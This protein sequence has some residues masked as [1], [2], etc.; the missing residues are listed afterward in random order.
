MYA[1]YEGYGTTF[2]EAEASCNGGPAAG[3]EAACAA[4]CMSTWAGDESEFGFPFLKT[5]GEETAYGMP[6]GCECGTPI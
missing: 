4:T 6:C 2:A 5:V 1:L 3:C